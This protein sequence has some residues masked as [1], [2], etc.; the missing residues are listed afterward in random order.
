MHVPGGGGGLV[1]VDFMEPT[2]TV[3]GL[4]KARLDGDVNAGSLTVRSSTA[5]TATADAHVTSITLLGSASGI[6]ADAEITSAAGNEASIGSS[7]TVVV[8]GAVDV[9]AI[10][11]SD[12]AATASAS[13]TGT[14]LIDAGIFV[15]TAKVGGSVLAEIDG[16]VTGSSLT[17]NGHGAN[18]ANATTTSFGIGAL[19]F[20]GAGTLAQITGSADVSATVGPTSQVSG[21]VSVTAHSA[22]TA[23]ATS[24]AASGSLAV[25]LAV[26]LPKA[27]VGGATLAEFDGDASATNSVLVQATSANNATATA[28]IFSIG[29]LGSIAAASSDAE[30]TSGA[31]TDAIVGS[32]SSISDPSAVIQVLATSANTANATAHGRTGT[33]G[34][35]VAVMI[36]SA[37]VGGATTAHFDGDIGSGLSLTVRSRTSNSAIA[38]AEIAAI[39]FLAGFGGG[40]AD[41]EIT[42]ASNEASIGSDSNITVSGAV[43]VDAGQNALN[44]SQA[45]I[46]GD[47]TGAISGT[48]MAAE[49][50]VGGSV[51]AAADGVVAGGSITISANG[52]NHADATT[53]SFQIGA[54]SFSGAGTFAEV[55]GGADVSAEAGSTGSLT[56]AGTISITA[57][58]H[59][60]ATATSDAASGGLIG[61]VSVNLPEALVNGGTLAE[62]DADVDPT[63]VELSAT[64]ANKANA[65]ANIFSIGGLASGA[66]A[67]SDAEIGSGATTNALVGSTSTIIASGAA[68]NVTATSANEAIAIA[69]GKTGT[70]GLAVAVMIPTAKVG[71]GTKA[72]FDG[73]IPA[74][75]GT[76]SL[77]IQSR[78]ANHANADAN[79]D[80]I[81]I[82]LAGVGVGDA[83][84]EITSGATNEASIGSHAAIVVSGAVTIDAGQTAANFAEATAEGTATGAISVGKFIAE[85][86]VDGAVLAEADGGVNGGSLDVNAT[87]ANTATATTKSFQISLLGFGGAGTLAEIGSDADVTAKVGSSALLQSNITVEAH[88]TNT[89]TAKS[90]AGSGGLVGA[91]TFNQPTALVGGGTTAEFDGD[92][93][94]GT[95]VSISSTSANSA[96]ATAEIFSIGLIASGA[97]ASSDAEVTS[98]ATTSATVGSTSSIDAP[99]VTIHE[100]ATSANAATA[101]ASGKSGSIGLSIVIMD[102]TAKVGGPTSASYDG[103][104]TH[105]AGL[106]I[107]TSTANDAN[108]HTNIVNIGLGASATGADRRCRDHAERRQRG[109]DRRA[110]DDQRQRRR[111][112]VGIPD[113][114]QYRDRERRRRRRRSDRSRLLLVRCA[115][116]RLDD[117]RDGRQRHGEHADRLGERNQHRQRDDGVGRDRRCPALQR[118]RHLRPHHERRG[119]DRA[120]RLDR[121]DLDHRRDHGHVDLG[122]HG[123]GDLRLGWRR[124][125]RLDDGRAADREGRRADLRRLRRHGHAVGRHH[126]LCDL[127]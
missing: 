67:S 6:V 44:H 101:T 123:D 82:G 89:A 43:N 114:G 59:N 105:A 90:D 37:A 53:S 12:N 116:R 36:P 87:G 21:P 26:N 64:S 38:D 97:G 16:N 75:G 127:R 79:V 88:S 4:T 86:H 85:A 113:G 25:G 80:A 102:P 55:T 83:D 39:S 32:T 49:A 31:S 74:F 72:S 34:L 11:S 65:T 103:D 57:S 42:S 94:N 117:G 56:S 3:A 52:T 77:T 20:S 96:S 30:T 98:G 78:T 84:A 33:L 120:G 111:H 115:R 58:S 2:A 122:Q 63:A 124:A 47:S 50:H 106:D 5:N 1:S 126:D 81:S 40:D 18:T 118:L 125:A 48:I 14:G 73:Q 60:S 35:A 7:S 109:V 13:G 104:I 54:L 93:Q 119:H 110:R 99:G 121:S 24:D 10:Q 19:S 62:L 107:Q 100:S 70:I 28:N 17:V 69:H 27:S 76:A 71:G 92:V 51:L 91:F 61:G 29:L 66:G 9:E 15:A 95:S 8:G 22:N 23:T 112:R 45:T 41:A 108:A 68:V 46:G